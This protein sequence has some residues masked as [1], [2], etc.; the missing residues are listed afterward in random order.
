MRCEQIFRLLNHGALNLQ[1][2]RPRTDIGADKCVLFVFLVVTKYFNMNV[3]VQLP[4][5]PPKL[6]VFVCPCWCKIF[7]GSTMDMEVNNLLILTK[8]KS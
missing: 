1:T 6:Q 7:G 3:S 5:I 2:K 8:K 4:A